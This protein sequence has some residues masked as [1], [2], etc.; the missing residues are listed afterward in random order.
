MSSSTTVDMNFLSDGVFSAIVSSGIQPKRSLNQL[1]FVKVNGTAYYCG[2]FVVLA[3]P[4]DVPLL[5]RTD[6]IYVKDM[7]CYLPVTKFH[8]KFDNHLSA[9]ATENERKHGV[10]IY[11]IENL[12]DFYPL[13]AYIV[14]NKKYVV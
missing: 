4:Y 7:V 12:L 9:Y 3:V 5:G 2:M 10:A 6:V 11:Q 1:K 13:S 8:A 14:M